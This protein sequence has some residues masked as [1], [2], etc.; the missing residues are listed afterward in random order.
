MLLY[1]SYFLREFSRFSCDIVVLLSMLFWP[2]LASVLLTILS[3][4][5]FFLSFMV[6]F[7]VGIFLPPY[8]WVKV[9]CLSSQ[10]RPGSDCPILRYRLYRPMFSRILDATQSLQMYSSSIEVL[11]SPLFD[12]RFFPCM[13]KLLFQ[14][15]FP[16]KRKPTK[17]PFCWFWSVTALYPLIS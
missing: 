11:G 16:T 12:I 15:E 13:T 4:H 8:F 7:P 6:D 9:R 3:S 14:F 5:R 10:G 17:T 2:C 1:L